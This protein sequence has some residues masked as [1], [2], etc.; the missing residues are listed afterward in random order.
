MHSLHILINLSINQLSTIS[1][2]IHQPFGQSSCQFINCH[3]NNL[4][5]NASICQFSFPF[6]SALIDCRSKLMIT[7]SSKAVT[8]NNR[9]TTENKIIIPVANSILYSLAYIAA[10]P[11][12]KQV[13]P[14]CHRKLSSPLSVTQTL[15]LCL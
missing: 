2:S 13:L 5:V 12:R 14:S 15:A 1:L 10:I 8:L 11:T 9:Y 6:L 7:F 4:S 3:P